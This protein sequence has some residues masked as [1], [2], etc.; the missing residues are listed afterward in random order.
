MDLTIRQK[1]AVNL[2]IECEKSVAKEVYDVSGA[3]DT[4][5]ALLGLGL[6]VGLNLNRAIKLANIAAGIKVRKLGTAPVLVDEIET[7]ILNMQLFNEKEKQ[8]NI[9]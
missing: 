9:L 2:F 8:S 4:V 6:C 1:D 3:G 5:I 7:E